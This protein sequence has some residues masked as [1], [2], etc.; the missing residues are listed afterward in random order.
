MPTQVQFR[1]GTTAQNNNFTGAAGELSVNTSNSSIRVHDGSTAGGFELANMNR[2][3]R[4]FASTT[5][6]ELRSV[7]SDETGT[8]NAVFSLSP[9]IQSPTVE[10]SIV[11]GNTTFNLVNTTATTVN[12]AGAATTLEIGA[13]TG[14]TNINNNLEVD[15]DIQ[16][17]GGD[18]TFNTSTA[19]IVNATSTTVNF[20]GAAT[21]LSIGAVS[22]TT[23][24]NNNLTVASNS[25][26][27]N[28]IVTNSFTAGTLQTS[29]NVNGNNG[30][31]VT[32]LSAGTLQSTGN[33]NAAAGLTTGNFTAANLLTSGNLD[34]AAALV[35]GNFNA[36]GNINGT[37]GRFSTALTAA[38]LQASGNVNAAAGRIA[39]NFSTTGVLSVSDTTAATGLNTGAAIISGGA[40]IGGNLYVGGNLFISG[41][42]TTLNSN[43]TILDDPILYLAD[44]S[45]SDVLDIGLVGTFNN[46]TQQHGG[47]VRD[48]TDGVWKIFSNV[49][50]EP[51]INGTVDFTSATYDAV[52]MGALTATSGTFSSTISATSSNVNASSAL[53][54]GSVTGGTLQTTGNVN[55]N[56]GNF[57]TALSA[58]TLQSTG[59]LNAAAGLISGNF[60][61]TGAV[62]A[63]SMRVGSSGLTLLGATSGTIALQPTSTAGTTT[64]TLPATT[65]TVVTT[66]DTGSVT[67]T[68]I[69]DGTIV[70]AD[71]NASAAIA[72]SKLAASTI[73]GITLGNNLNGLT[74]GTGLSGTAYNG[75]AAQTWTLATSGV[76]A[77]TYGGAGTVPVYTV[78]TYGR[79]T[80]ASNVAIAGSLTGITGVGTI[81]TGTWQGSSISTTYTDAKLTSVS[82]TSPIATSASTGAITLS[83]ASSGVTA[84]TY[85]SAGIVPV[86]TVNATGHITS[87]SN[88]TIGGSLTGITGVGT[89]TTGT[90][91]GSSISTSYTDAKV[92]AGNAGTG[93]SVN[94]T[95]GSLTVTNSGVTSLVAGTNI[96]ISGSTGAVTVN[97]SG[98][99]SAATSATNATNTAI[100]DDTSTN[101][102][103]YPTYVSA[104]SGNAGQ[105][106][107]SSKF[108]F[109]PS[110]G[111]LTSTDYNSSSD[112]RLKTNIKTVESALDKV[113]SLR[114]VTFKWKEGG[115]EAIGLI[116]QEVQKV[117]PEVVTKDDSGYLGIRYTNIIG[118]LVEAIKEQ[119]DQINTLKKQIEKLN[120]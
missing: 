40:S 58:A 99:V 8:G 54:T 17:D 105:K 101:S 116:A 27:S 117:I 21:T 120:G 10:T 31:F 64:I 72:V 86:Y 109:N 49:V 11:A 66:G 32:A 80:S 106:T 48:A 43:V 15:G 88:V 28:G 84:A 118:V 107:S 111:L 73:S 62:N 113:N 110:S 70:N 16:I 100:T 82:A 26:A 91:N 45:T 36:T 42:T 108:T 93:I 13:A 104:T 53:F 39:G 63:A 74:A 92:T 55:G 89:I 14:L 1:R 57:S 46:G 79:L 83:H 97:V 6:D 68:M 115:N 103:H 77:S 24:V 47:F 94:Q 5:S 52:R 44:N 9:T 41:T 60:N 35:S 18:L 69:A 51:N 90:W 29:G 7:L 78:D 59:N 65:G 38:T 19:N 61:A 33:I 25:L 87:A 76:T 119:Q 85:G 102:T 56:N 50:P 114:G 4:Q 12:F 95:T 96:S 20:A 22:G 75:S 23:T 71:I 30:N 112:K 81:S 98:T 34:A 2:S 67:S 3:L 37:D